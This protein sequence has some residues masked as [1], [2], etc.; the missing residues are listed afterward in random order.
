MPV[1]NVYKSI[2]IHGDG[3]I[4]TA[5]PERRFVD[6]KQKLEGI[7]VDKPDSRQYRVD[8]GATLTA[9]SGS[10]TL[11]VDGTTEFALTLNT[12]QTSTYRLTATAG[13]A[14]GFRTARSLALNTEIFTVTVNN[15]STVDFALASGSSGTFAAVTVGD[16][17]FIPDTTTG[18]SASVF[19][20]LNIGFWV[21]LAKGSVSAV[22]NKKLTLA[23]MPGEDFEGVA[24]SVTLTA[25][26]QFQAYSA[27]GVQKD[28]T[29][30]VSSGFSSVT[31]KS[32]VVSRVTDSW[33]EFTSTEK[34]PL[35]DDITPTAAGLTIYT[36]AKRFIYVE[37][38]QESVVRLNG[39]TGNTNRLSPRVV[40]DL[41]KMAHMEKWGPVWRL[42]IINRS[43][44]AVMTINII[45][46]E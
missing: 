27:A 43:N 36:N 14:A 21:V 22:A 45:S 19:S 39:D 5:N 40:G 2:L 46:A 3:E 20:P 26:S 6:W 29:L 35:E 15:N 7:S 34:L 41:D 24:E 8:P 17:I 28:D 12:T 42:D 18:D 13:T 31:Q 23:R 32:F 11:L 30:E 9:F 25:S 33:V 37:A 4:A 44:S 10:R 38:D 16:T 1:L